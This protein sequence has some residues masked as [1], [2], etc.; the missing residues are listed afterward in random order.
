MLVIKY[1]LA[2][3][4]FATLEHFNF[5]GLIGNASLMEVGEKTIKLPVL[6]AIILAS[7]ISLLI[8]DLILDESS[9]NATKDENKN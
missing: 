6:D 2:F 8:A 7:F 3:G 9:R 4:V 1:I 5:I